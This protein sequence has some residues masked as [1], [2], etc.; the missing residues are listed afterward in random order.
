ML[1]EI[2]IHL[3]DQGLNPY[4]PG[5]H[6]GE[7]EENY[8][9]IKQGTQMPSLQSRKLG[10]LVMDFILLIPIYDYKEMKSYRDNIVQALKELSYLRKT[11]TETPIITDDE[12]K[13]YTTSI[14]Y[15]IQKKL[16]G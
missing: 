14:E 13:A 5:K 10:Q 9:I 12:K 8:V 1:Q 6:R 4:F 7:C 2:Y 16:E 15:V 11:G 3:K